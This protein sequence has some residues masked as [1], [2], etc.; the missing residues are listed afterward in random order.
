MVQQ[1][2]GVNGFGAIAFFSITAIGTQTSARTGTRTICGAF[3]PHIFAAYAP[4]MYT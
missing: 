3:G 1:W 4:C 2:F